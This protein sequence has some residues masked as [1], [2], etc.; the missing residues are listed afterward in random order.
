M[1]CRT[2]GLSRVLACILLASGFSGEAFAQAVERNLPPAQRPSAPIPQGPEAA[3]PA[4]TREIAG[5]PLRGLTATSEPQP[6]PL[7]EGRGVL[8]AGDDLRITGPELAAVLAR[9]E[10]QPITTNVVTAIQGEINAV[11]QRKGFPF[12]AAVT[13]PQDLSTGV[14]GLRIVEFRIGEVRHNPA[15]GAAAQ[16]DVRASVRLSPGDEIPLRRLQE[17]LVWLNRYPYRTVEA[18]FRPG[19]GVGETDLILQTARTRALTVFGGYGNTGSASTGWNRVYAGFQAGIPGLRDVIAAYQVTISPEDLGGRSTRGYHSQAVLVSGPVAHRAQVDLAVNWVQSHQVVEVFDLE[20]TLSEAALSYR[21][22][23][24]NLTGSDQAP[25]DAWVGL[26]ARRQT[27]VSAFGDVRISSSAFNAYHLVAGYNR[28]HFGPGS[29]TEVEVVLRGSPG[30]IGDANSTDRLSASTQGRVDDARYAYTSLSLF[31]SRGVGRGVAVHALVRAQVA[32]GAL[33]RSEQFGLGG[34]TAARGYSHDDGAADQGMLLQGDIEFPAFPIA[35]GDLTLQPLLIFD[36]SWGKPFGGGP[37]TRLADLG[38]GASARF[39]G[40][41]ELRTTV[42][43][44]LSD[45]S[46]TRAGDVRAVTRL[47]LRF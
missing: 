37:E 26:E 35:S 8:V 25:G 16:D 41:V 27:S 15:K 34:L 19:A 28:T 3:P 18:V 32:S 39:A 23:I 22:A 9:Y 21:F 20:D 47:T 10:G 36:A 5:P 40:R 31:H 14:L 2:T 46:R 42:A 1:T 33:P 30:D 38:L 6:A 13:P 17:D 44:A 4:S 45:G 7:P 11:Y 29:Q 12:V 24:S 43:G